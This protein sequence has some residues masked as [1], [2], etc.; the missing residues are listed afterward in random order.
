MVCLT[1]TKQ[2][3]LSSPTSNS[4]NQPTTKLSKL[5]DTTGESF[6]SSI[7]FIASPSVF[8][9]SHKCILIKLNLLK[10]THYKIHSNLKKIFALGLYTSRKKCQRGYLLPCCCSRSSSTLH[11]NN[12]PHLKLLKAKIHTSCKSRSESSF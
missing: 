3:T 1:D 7:K 5:R 12:I 4:L 8:F 11:S 6:Q 10:Y 2:W 9:N